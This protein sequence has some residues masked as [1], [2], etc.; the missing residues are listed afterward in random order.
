MVDSV[1][2][3]FYLGVQ[4]YWNKQA[5]LLRLTTSASDIL[6][7]TRTLPQ[8]S[9]MSQWW[10]WLIGVYC[11]PFFGGDRNPCLTSGQQFGYIQDFFSRIN[12]RLRFFM[13]CW[14]LTIS[15]CWWGNICLAVAIVLLALSPLVWAVLTAVSACSSSCLERWHSWQARILGD[16]ILFAIVARLLFYLSSRSRCGKRGLFG[17]I[18]GLGTF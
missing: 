12:V 1:A 5:T 4:W 16:C 9:P 13:V 17:L 6:A 18:R 7:L 2:W 3:Y 10:G 15:A 14:A 8:I 11:L